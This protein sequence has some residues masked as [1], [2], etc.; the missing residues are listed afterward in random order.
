MPITQLCLVFNSKNFTSKVI[1]PWVY[2][3]SCFPRSWR[4]SNHCPLVLRV[5]P[6]IAWPLCWGLVLKLTVCWSLEQ[7]LSNNK[8]WII[9]KQL[10]LIQW[11]FDEILE[12]LGHF[13]SN[14]A[15]LV[16]SYCHRKHTF[17][18]LVCFACYPENSTSMTS[19]T[20]DAY[21]PYVLQKFYF[22]F[23]RLVQCDLKN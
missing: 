20:M 8:Y 3:P 6:L 2:Q 7:S 18:A 10:M 15:S 13:S 11:L 19:T 9:L 23:S 17:Q 5:L 22:Y 1:Y 14:W 16:D 21:G 4:Y 12:C